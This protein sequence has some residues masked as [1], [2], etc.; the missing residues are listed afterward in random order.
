[1]PLID[2]VVVP[3]I[4][5]IGF[6]AA[7]EL[8]V[9]STT[10]A[11]EATI[12]S[13][14]AQVPNFGTY[15]VIGLGTPLITIVSVA[16]GAVITLR[17][18]KCLS[19]PCPDGFQL[20]NGS[21]ARKIPPSLVPSPISIVRTRVVIYPRERR[22]HYYR[23]SLRSG[24]SIQSQDEIDYPTSTYSTD[25]IATPPINY[26]NDKIGKMVHKRNESGQTQEWSALR[27]NG[28]VVTVYYAYGSRDESFSELSAA[29][30]TVLSD[31]FNDWATARSVTSSGSDDN[32]VSLY[33]QYIKRVLYQYQVD[34]G[35]WVTITD[36]VRDNMPYPLLTEVSP[37]APR[38]IQ[39]VSKIQI[40]GS[41]SLTLPSI[42]VG[43]WE[44]IPSV[45]MTITLGEFDN[46]FPDN[47]L[48]SLSHLVVNEVVKVTS[49]R[50]GDT[51]LA[52]IPLAGTLLSNLLDFQISYRVVA[53]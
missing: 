15:T 23:S 51:L 35:P 22:T 9:V 40:R 14:L 26:I 1:M 43:E 25:V 29:N 42:T 48:S 38:P 50:L 12:S 31:E 21:C 30:G 24:Y 19:D 45:G 2:T 41:I 47:D 13:V 5:N 17:L 28:N 4:L 27:L 7:G 39:R 3:Q 10:S 6:E 34:N 49:T 44:L 8:A 18:L 52:A 16:T 20:V 46:P 32:N 37:T 36:D 53:Y 33:I 11:L